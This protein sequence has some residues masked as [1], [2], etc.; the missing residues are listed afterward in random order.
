MQ[1]SP[2]WLPFL[3]PFAWA[4]LRDWLLSAPTWPLS[5][6]PMLH[7][8]TAPPAHSHNPRVRRQRTH[9][10]PYCRTCQLDTIP[11]HRISRLERHA[12][13]NYFLFSS[14]PK[15]CGLYQLAPATLL[16]SLPVVEAA[17]S[18]CPEALHDCS[19]LFPPKYGGKAL[20]LSLYLLLLLGPG[21][22]TCTFCPA[23]G[24]WPSLLSN[25]EPIREINLIF[26]A[27]IY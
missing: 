14:C 11:G 13:I 3:S 25:Q 1:P 10:Q 27:N 18:S 23:M 26:L 4:C 16:G 24:S 12:L 17:G 7:Q 9:R 15:L 6:H 20:S 2:P 22:L 5:T 19:I 21:S 8:S